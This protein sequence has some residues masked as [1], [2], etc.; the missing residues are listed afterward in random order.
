MLQK[1]NF[2]KFLDAFW[3]NEKRIFAL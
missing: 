3:V 1:P 2:E